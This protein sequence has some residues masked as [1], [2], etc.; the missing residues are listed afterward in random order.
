MPISPPRDESNTTVVCGEW[1]VLKLYRRTD[2][3]TQP[4]L[5]IGHVLTTRGF[6]HTPPVVGALEHHQRHRGPMALVLVQRLVP[7]KRDAWE[8]TLA[9]LRRDFRRARSSSA[10]VPAVSLA[11]A[12]LLDGAVQEPPP[13]APQWFAPML[14]LARRLAQRT[15]ELHLTLAAE[16]GDP[17]S[18]PEPLTA[19]DRRPLYQSLRN[20]TLPVF[21]T[22][23]QHWPTLARAAQ[24]EASQVLAHEAEVL[25]SFR[26]LLQRPLTAK[27][28]RC[29]GNYHFKPVLCTGTDLV[30][31]DF[32]G[33][34][35][36][37]L[38]ERRL[39]RPALHEE[40]SS[41]KLS[42]LL[43]A[44]VAVVLA[45]LILMGC[46]AMAGR[47]S[48]RAA[49]DDTTITT[50]VKSSL[51]ADPVV[52]AIAIDVDTTN[53]VVSLN[54]IVNSEQERQR[55]VQLAQA[56]MGVKRVD[57]CNLVVRR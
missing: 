23:R 47:Q 26:T 35:A 10:H 49:A 20:L 25:G 39:K 7:H 15:A 48:A 45:V 3:G 41:M 14:E 4:E 32:E 1:G 31:I 5:E 8:Y 2:V 27:R 13:L 56:V 6:A 30:I 34:P 21:Q 57:G 22:P 52:S 9:R 55:A 42:N 29:H 18:A 37:P 54:G 38:F 17:A 24:R 16:T 43:K 46:G 40:K 19:L 11:M 28:I 33:E 50:K 44:Q 51:L 53:G 36:R 12:A